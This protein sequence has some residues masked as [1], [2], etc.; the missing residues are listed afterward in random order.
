MSD[1]LPAGG[2]APVVPELDVRDLAR[3]L[4][5]WCDGIGFAVAYDRPESGFACLERD[6]AQ[7]MLNLING[8]WATAPLAPPFGRGIN[9]QIA[10]RSISGIV[11]RL[12]ALD[13]PLFRPPHD[14]WYRVGDEEVGCRQF[15]VQDP[16]GYLLRFS[17]SRGRRPFSPG[18]PAS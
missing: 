7:V 6:G 5:F 16:D 2:F 13:W 1:R 17:E 15:L 4:A 12:A 9:L 11:A 18:A 8:A 10:V 3:S 14:A